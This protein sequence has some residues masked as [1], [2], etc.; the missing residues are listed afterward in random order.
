MFGRS[1]PHL[2]NTNTKPLTKCIQTQNRI[3]SSPN[4]WSYL[5]KRYIS[6]GSGYHELS[7]SAWKENRFFRYYK[8]SNKVDGMIEL[9][10]RTY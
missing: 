10:F 4:V 8:F 2:L 5:S 3:N 6:P 9:Y 7:Q 1:L